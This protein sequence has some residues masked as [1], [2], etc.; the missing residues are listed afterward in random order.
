MQVLP[1][2]PDRLA[3]V[4]VSDAF[5]VVQDDGASTDPA[6]EV[7][8]V[9]HEENGAPLR[10]KLLHAVEALLL[11]HLVA[12]GQHL[13]DQQDV[14]VDVDGDG[15]TKAYEHAGRVVL[16]LAVDGVFELG[17]RNDVVEPAGDFTLGDAKE[18]RVD[19]DVLAPGEIGVKPAPSSSSDAMRPRTRHLAGGRQQDSRDALEQRRLARAV[20]TQHP[21]RL[22][23][24]N[25][26]VELLQ[27]PQV[28][29]TL[30]P[31]VNE[32]VLQ[33]ADRILHDAEPLGDPL[34][35]DRVHQIASAK[36]PS[37]R[38]KIHRLKRTRNAEMASTMS[39]FR[40]YQPGPSSGNST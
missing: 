15:E 5:T 38:S 1:V 33:R 34:R 36:L 4:S 12:D 32:A 35:F 16:H 21:Q 9:A 40:R 26:E 2:D 6:H 18:R 30:A 10:L 22:A 17:E 13:V 24:L 20:V 3:W 28:A 39:T 31:K 27:C 11:K 25:G 8:A 23:L 19:E 7:G 37:A 14:R 29:V